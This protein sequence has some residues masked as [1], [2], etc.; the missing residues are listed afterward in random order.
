MLTYERGSY[1]EADNYLNRYM[2]LQQPTLD[3]L[4]LGV[5]ISRARH[6]AAAADS[7]MQQLRRRFPDARETQELAQKR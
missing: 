4:V 5:R 2:R 3:A 1:E 6:D 7:Y